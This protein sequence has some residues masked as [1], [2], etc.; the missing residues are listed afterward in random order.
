[1]VRLES[2][3]RGVITSTAVPSARISCCQRHSHEKALLLPSARRI[4][5]VLRCCALGR[6]CRRPSTAH[7][8]SSSNSNSISAAQTLV[9]LKQAEF[10]EGKKKWESDGAAVE[11]SNMANV[12]SQMDKDARK[13]AAEK[14]PAWR[15]CGAAPGL[16][17]SSS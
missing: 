3:G 4:T 14:E 12:G 8:S 15:G 9:L 10:E 17:V 13:G 1:M 2:N 5:S 7:R 16:E 6:R 11:D